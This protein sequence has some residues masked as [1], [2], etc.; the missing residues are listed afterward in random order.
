VDTLQ[1]HQDRIGSVVLGTRW[2]G[3][4]EK[5]EVWMQRQFDP[6]GRRVVSIGW[7]RNE[8]E[9]PYGF[10]GQRLDA[11]TG[12]YL[13]GAR[14]YSAELGR[15]IEQDP[16]AEGGGLNLYAYVGSSPT[17]WVDPSGLRP[18]DPDPLPGI[19]GAS[20][21]NNPL[22]QPKY[23]IDG[24]SA[25]DPVTG[26]ALGNR[27]E[28]ALKAGEMA[29][30]ASD[31]S[32]EK[33]IEEA[34]ETASVDGKPGQLAAL[35]MVEAGAVVVDLATANLAS[36]PVPAD[37]TDNLS[38][39]FGDYFGDLKV[40][41]KLDFLEIVSE[42]LGTM[43]TTISGSALLD[44]LAHAPGATQ[45]VADRLG[46]TT[47]T[48]MSVVGRTASVDTTVRLNPDQST[49]GGY[50]AT[51]L[52][53]ELAHSM[54][55][56]M[57]TAASGESRMRYRTAGAQQI[58]KSTYVPKAELQVIGLGRWRGDLITENAFRAELGRELRVHH[59]AMTITFTASVGV[60][61]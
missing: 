34:I 29:Q 32:A 53:H 61:P 57:A 15:F 55:G 28:G 26:G 2:N 44:N 35:V 45:V 17:L 52:F 51:T 19:P 6:Y 56:R 20:G 25:V 49:D 9:Q 30:D 47:K 40:E 16:I 31:Y 27:V 37:P 42:D 18:A 10:A 11:E 50:S 14:W 48:E 59:E 8:P 54:H 38:V 58:M 46:S 60:R 5:T 12:L 41:G 4:E 36:D 13:M 22:D 33:K 39:Q 23:S 43:R 1:L 21:S 3:A 7:E 24:V